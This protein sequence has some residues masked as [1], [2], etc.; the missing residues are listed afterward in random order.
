MVDT[1]ISIKTHNDSLSL[2]NEK[3]LHYFS[4]SAIQKGD[5]RGFVA[6]CF[7]ST[8]FG[9]T[10]LARALMLVVYF[11]NI[12]AILPPPPAKATHN[13]DFSDL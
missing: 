3:D 2:T 5:S 11:R 12:S 4:S 7:A 10:F 6:I 1:L 9:Q 8:H 13:P